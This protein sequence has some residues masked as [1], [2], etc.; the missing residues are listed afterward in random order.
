MNKIRIPS[1]FL[2]GLLQIIANDHQRFPAMGGLEELSL[3]KTNQ[4]G[5]FIARLWIWKQVL[6]SLPIF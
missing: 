5:K 1:F 3:N 6:F 4:Q 2:E